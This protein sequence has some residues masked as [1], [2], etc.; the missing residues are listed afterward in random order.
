M[1]IEVAGIGLTQILSGVSAVSSIIGGIQQSKEA[2]KQA[3]LAR[4]D[5]EARARE[6][7]RIALEFEERQKL[8][9][10][11]SGVQLEGSPLLVLAETRR[12]GLE[13]VQNV[14][15]TG[16]ARASAISSA[17]RQ[18]LFSGLTGGLTSAVSLVGT[19]GPE[20]FGVLGGSDP[21]TSRG[22]APLGTPPL[23]PRKPLLRPLPTPTT[24]RL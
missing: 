12:K 13:N 7:A 20:D 14:L 3:E 15:D 11:K 5:A 21:F 4:L 16:A 10:L 18:S 9:F 2:D 1:G 6:E 24:G 8:A 23:P 17:G 22:S 19:G